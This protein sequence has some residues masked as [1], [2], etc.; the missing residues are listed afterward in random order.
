[1][2]ADGAG[3]TR[4]LDLKF[5]TDGLGETEMAVMYDPD[6]PESAWIRAPRKAFLEGVESYR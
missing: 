3:S 4:G 2:S 5:M 1:M 6:A